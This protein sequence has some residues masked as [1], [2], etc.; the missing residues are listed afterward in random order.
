MKPSLTILIPTY[1]HPSQVRDCVCS[2]LCNTEYPYKIIVLNNDPNPYAR[3]ILDGI[4]AQSKYE[5][6]KVKHLGANKGWMGAINAGM[7]EVDT[8]FVCLLNDDV[9]FIPGQLDFW[10]LLITWLSPGIG[11][12]GPCSNFVMGT[13]ALQ[14]YAMPTVTLVRFLIGFCLVMRTEVFRKVGMLDE[15]LP[16]GDDLDLSMRLRDA[17]YGLICNRIAYLHHIGSQTGMEVH[18]NFWNSRWQQDMTNNALIRKYGVKNWYLTIC[19]AETTEVD[20][21]ASYVETYNAEE[22]WKQSKVN[23]HEVGLDL[24]CGARVMGKWGLD[25][26]RKGEKGQGGMKLVE[27]QPD[28][29]G[30]AADL[31]VG[32]AQLDY[33]YASHL[34][35]H[36]LDP[37]VAL[38]EWRRVVKVGGRLILTLPDHER[39]NSIIVDSSHLHA[40]TTESIKTLLELTG[41]AVIDTAEFPTAAFGV[42]A[43]AV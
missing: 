23:G 28:I 3:E 20:V 29:T 25:V 24:G 32:E 17:G 9:L 41:W 8:E 10:R 4:F 14:L 11:A 38:K 35:E 7:E 33:I 19:G 27:T 39:M 26:R 5:H 21:E 42:E 13:Q 6:L 2:M 34:F 15:N 43:K 18:G 37:I 1:R 16:G 30:N 22:N 40:Y 36:L 31:P 12:V